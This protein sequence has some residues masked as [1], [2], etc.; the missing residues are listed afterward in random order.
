MSPN[1]Q[2]CPYCGV[3]QRNSD[4]HIFPAFLGGQ[5]TIRACK[6]CN[7]VF[8][9]SFEGPLSNDFAPVVIIIRRGGIHPPK[10][11]VWKRAFKIGGVDHDLDSDLKL[12]PS[13]PS[14]DRDDLGAIKQGVFSGKKAA[15]GFIRGQEAAGK[16]LELIPRSQDFPIPKI[17]FDLNIGME[18]RRLAIKTAVAAADHMGFSSGLLDEAAREFLFG[19]V[20]TS[21]RVRIDLNIR[22]ELE[23]LRPPLSH[24]VFVKGNSQTRTSY[25]IVQFYG[26]FQLYAL[27]NPGQ[28]AGEDFAIVAFLDVAKEYAEHFAQ[29]ELFKFPE[30]PV[31]MAYWKALE[32][33]ADWMKKFRSETR[34][35]LLNEASLI[36]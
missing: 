20:P 3:G 29:T 5:T 32:L 13:N 9:H 7:D 28:F 15:K 30:V 34:A 11:V 19:I 25:A 14:F 26:L 6:Q 12:T 10:V 8:G 22:E 31:E 36:F 24:F 16:R 1:S 4:D 21:D 33:K 18:V 2:L 35:V 27:L 17:N 23:K